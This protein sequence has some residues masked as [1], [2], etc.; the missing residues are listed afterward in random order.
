MLTFMV[1]LSSHLDNIASRQAAAGD[2]SGITLRAPNKR[3][4]AGRRERTWRWNADPFSARSSAMQGRGGV[5]Y[6][7]S[8]RGQDSDGRAEQSHNRADP[9]DSQRRRQ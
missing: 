8:E 5:G 1:H 3:N 2:T 9:G 7:L 4:A 6:P